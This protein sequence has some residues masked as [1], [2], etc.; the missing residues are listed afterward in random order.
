MISFPDVVPKGYGFT[1]Y[2]EDCIS[3]TISVN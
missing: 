1:I 3:F 2:I